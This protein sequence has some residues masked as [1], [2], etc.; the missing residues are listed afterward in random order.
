VRILE[1]KVIFLLEILC[2]SALHSLSTLQLQGEPV[3]R[4]GRK[5]HNP[6]STPPLYSHHQ[7]PP[8]AS[9]HPLPSLALMGKQTLH[10]FTGKPKDD[11]DIP[12]KPAIS[13]ICISKA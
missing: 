1:L 11:G 13:L 9:L 8:Q 3:R 6:A 2:H 7:R 12:Q 4:K 5:Y 10:G